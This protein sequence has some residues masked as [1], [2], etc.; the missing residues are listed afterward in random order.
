MLHLSSR[1]EWAVLKT[2]VLVISL[3]FVAK[4]RV[5]SL[6]TNLN[7][8]NHD[9]QLTKKKHE[10]AESSQYP[11]HELVP[12]HLPPL[13]PLQPRSSAEAP[14]QA[15]SFEF[16]VLRH[17]AFLAHLNGGAVRWRAGAWYQLSTYSRGGV[18]WQHGSTP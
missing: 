17:V 16:E 7:S 8:I 1:R 11:N 15:S 3:N 14:R 5:F 6:K 13:Q 18:D 4:N 10:S 9:T 12:Q 2:I